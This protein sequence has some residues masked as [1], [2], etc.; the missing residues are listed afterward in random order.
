M[1]KGSMGL[2]YQFTI[3]KSLRND[4]HQKSDY[5]SERIYNID[6]E[7]AFRLIRYVCRISYHL[8]LWGVLCSRTEDTWQIS[9]SGS[10]GCFVLLDVVNCICISFCSQYFTLWYP[11]RNRFLSINPVAVLQAD[12]FSPSA[13]SAVLQYWISIKRILSN[14]HCTFN[15]SFADSLHPLQLLE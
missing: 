6:F 15:R 1:G 5:Q 13:S 3:A 9:C 11:M 2:I 12:S 10:S 7:D 8:S 4:N 14:V